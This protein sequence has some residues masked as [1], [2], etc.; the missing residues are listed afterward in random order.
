MQEKVFFKDSLGNNVYGILSNPAA[1]VDAPIIILCHGFSS[2]KE[3]STYVRLEEVFNN[4]N[5]PTLRF[6]FYGHGES[7]GEFKDISISKG[8][9]DILCAINFLKEKGFS[10]IGLVG[11][12]FAGICITMAASKSN[13]LFAL[14]LRAPV[15][16]YYATIEATRSKEEI[17][18]WKEKGFAFYVNGAGKHL[19]L[20]YSFYED[21]KNNDVYAVAKNISIPVIIAHGDNDV[22]VSLNQSKKLATILPDCVLKIIPGAG[23]SFKTIEGQFEEVI[24]LISDF[25][26]DKS[27]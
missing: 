10:K 20:N 13:D 15:S 18:E 4:Q 25:M 6:D 26:I 24:S 12:S 14:G 1:N 21:F 9:D 19:K 8:V 2:S 3:S 5:F 7:D 23:H 17:N 11:S 22:R 27:K 16:D